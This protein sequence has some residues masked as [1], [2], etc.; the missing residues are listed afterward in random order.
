MA[1]PLDT[2]ADAGTDDLR[3]E[4]TD[5]T[6]DW[7]Y[8]DPD[9]DTVEA[10]TPDVI[11]DDGESDDEDPETTEDEADETDGKETDEESAPA[12]ELLE[13]PDGTKVERDEVVKGYLRQSDYTRKT[14][15]VATMRKTL[16]AESTRINGITEA[17]IDRLSRLIPAAPEPGLAY[18]DPSA[19]T[20]QKAAHDAAVNEVQQFIKIGSEAKEAKGAVSDVEQQRIRAE[21]NRALIEKFPETENPKGREA[22]FKRTSEAAQSVGFSIDELRGVTDHRMFALAHLASL[23]MKAQ[24]AQGKARE[25]AAKAPPATPNKP[26]NTGRNRAARN[27]EAMARL[28]KEGSIEAAMRVDFE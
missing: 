3:P 18:R 11:E 16:E 17:F 13:L 19:Y 20:R 4:Q 23:G 8:Y 21:E 1:D 2:P 6:P 9:E 12:P 28:S 14:S 22:F 26:G 15:E 5:T 27:R 7:D 25:K 10:E 24:A